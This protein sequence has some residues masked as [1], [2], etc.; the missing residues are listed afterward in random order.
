[1]TIAYA[2]QRGMPE[3][4]RIA[5]DPLAGIAH[6]A[7]GSRRTGEIEWSVPTVGTIYGALLNFRGALAALGDAVSAP[8]YATPPHAPILYVKPANTWI[9]YGARIPL[10]P[11]VPQLLMGATLGVVIGRTACRVPVGRALEFVRGYAVVNDVCEP[12]A[13]V[14]R[15]AIRQRCRDGF[16]AIGPWIVDRDAV[17]APDALALRVFVNGTLRCANTTANLVR[18]VAWLIADVTQFL[19]L[20]EGDVLLVGTPENV[21]LAGS[22]DLVR[23]EI[24]G[25]GALENTV[26][27]EGPR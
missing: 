19:T 10:P 3:A 21:P 17:P 25:V 12:H 27:A 1:M 22:G 16:C 18:P 7:D 9:P 6:L 13:S 14:Y 24:D 2:R 26:E 15:P 11:G 23:I 20:A 4:E 5:V 8:P